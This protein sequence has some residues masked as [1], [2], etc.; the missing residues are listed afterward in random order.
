MWPKHSS[1]FH[2]NTS[3]VTM[4]PNGMTVNLYFPTSVLKVVRYKE[5]VSSVWCQYPFFQSH[6]VSMQASVKRWVISW[7]VWKWYGSLMTALFKLVGSRQILSLTCPWLSLFS[8]RTKL[9]IHHVALFTGSR[10][11]ACSI[12]LI[13]FWNASLRW[14]GMGLHGVCFSVTV[15][16]TWIWY[17][18]PG[19]FPM[20]LKTYGYSCRFAFDWWL[21]WVVLIC[22]SG[23]CGVDL[24]VSL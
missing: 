11:L 1:S 17:G 21:V 24:P 4:M 6:I 19:N 13:S 14:I 23:G 20:P 10:T 12:W 9:L 3:L 22:C 5:A 2:W 8:T 7:G 18:G 15:G 16:S